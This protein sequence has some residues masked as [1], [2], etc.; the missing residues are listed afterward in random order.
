MVVHV[1]CDKQDYW[2]V[3]VCAI[4]NARSPSHLLFALPQSSIASQIFVKNRNFCLPHPHSTP[5]GG[6]GHRRNIAITFGAEKKLD[7]CGYRMVKKFEHM[8]MPIRFDSI[9][10]RD[11]YADGRTPHD[12]TGRACTTSCGKHRSRKAKSDIRIGHERITPVKRAVG[13]PDLHV[14]SPYSNLY[15]TRSSAV[16]DRPPDAPCHWKSCCHSRSFKVIRN[17]TVE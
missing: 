8:F 5:P 6:R 2:C 16:A 10:E 3:A 15:F 13:P 1:G 9:H 7:R 17:Y 4:N 12:G 11:R 14:N